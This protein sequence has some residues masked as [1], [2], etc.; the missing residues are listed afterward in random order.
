MSRRVASPHAAW[1]AVLVMSVPAAG[2]AQ[3]AEDAAPRVDEVITATNDVRDVARLV[4]EGEE[5]VLLATDGGLVIR[6]GGATLRVL[7]A[8]DGLPGARLRSVSVTA[9]G[10]WVGAVEGTALLDTETYQVRRRLA[11]RRVVRVVTIDGADVAAT[12]GDGLWRLPA[13]ATSDPTPV[14]LGRSHARRRLTDL[15][16]V[17]DELWVATSGAGILRLSAQGRIVGR[18]TRRTGLPSNVVW[19][20]AADGRDVL[21]A[22]FGGLAVVAD[23]GRVRHGHALSRAAAEIPIADLRAV[24]ATHDGVLVG[25][26]GAGVHRLRGVRRTVVAE[27]LRVHVLVDFAEDGDD[28]GALLGH[29]EG[30]ASV[31]PH[32]V[33]S[34]ATGGLPSSDVTALARAHGRTWIGTFSHGLAVL[35][36]HEIMPMGRATERWG[37]DRRIND[38]AV[39]TADD[40]ERL[41]VATDRGLFVHDGLRFTPVEHED[42]PGPVHVTS[43]HV[44]ARGRLWVTSSRMLARF[45]GRGWHSWRGDESLPVLQLHAV[46]VADDG[47]VWIGSLHGL[48]RLDLEGD[49]FTRH[50]VSSGDLPVDWVTALVPFDQGVMVGTY[51]GGLAMAREGTFTRIGEAE[52]LPA[53]WVNP[54]AMRVVGEQLFVGTLEG[55]LVVGRPGAWQHLTVAD[56]L[57]SDDVTAV[58]PA[59]PTSVWV[60][61]RGGLARLAMP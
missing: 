53:T 57:P 29:A 25:S 27:G 32:G 21:A 12:F 40:G 9:A 48:Y 39:T 6:Q 41:W 47:S 60:A 19:D 36:G 13:D 44:D 1:L 26:W 42:A 52:G 8:R 46:T 35:D 31:G 51:H 30:L 7:T 58:L 38:L 17:R 45:D 24:S 33:Q 2:S 5:R 59:S 49:R 34:V 11:L 18:L 37:V 16:P 3:A 55:G 50:T 14:A 28:H 54:H 22:A 43:L 23:S 15:L 20:L 4:A 56:G 61:T 10:I